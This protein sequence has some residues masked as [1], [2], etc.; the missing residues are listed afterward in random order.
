MMVVMRK[1]YCT[2]SISYHLFH[3][4]IFQVPVHKHLN[5]TENVSITKDMSIHTNTALFTYLVKK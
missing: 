2:H 4:I 5:N 1:Q 3:S